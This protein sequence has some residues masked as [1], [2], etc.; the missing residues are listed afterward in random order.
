MRSI[1]HASLLHGFAFDYAYFS[2][3][4]LPALARVKRSQAHALKP[5]YKAGRRGGDSIAR[6][7]L[8]MPKFFC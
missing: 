7:A 6:G 5:T 4:A 1:K 8:S 3:I 2:R